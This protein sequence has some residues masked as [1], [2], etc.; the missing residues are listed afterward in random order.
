Q[1]R[2]RAF[3]DYL[4]GIADTTYYAGKGKLVEPCPDILERT[5]G[6]RPVTDDNMGTE[7]RHPFGLE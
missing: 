4:D 1:S 7:W 5:R 6:L 2:D 3:V